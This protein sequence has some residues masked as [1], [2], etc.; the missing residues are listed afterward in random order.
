[1]P[2]RSSPLRTVRTVHTLIRAFVGACILAIPL[3]AW[4]GRPGVALLLIGI[5][6][7]EVLVLVANGWRCPRTAV[8]ARYTDDRCDNFAIYL[9]A[10][11]ARNNKQ[12]L[13]S[14][15]VGGVARTAARWLAWL[16][17]ATP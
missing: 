14:L 13:G 17:R 3:L 9:P 12:I 2:T 6:S 5:V 16:D 4:A 7:V 10:W 15:F 11:L 8:A 1:M